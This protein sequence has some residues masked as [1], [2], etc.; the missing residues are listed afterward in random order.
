[1]LIHQTSHRRSPVL[2]TFPM[3]NAHLWVKGAK[4]ML[5][6]F[7]FVFDLGVSAGCEEDLLGNV[8]P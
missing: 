1:M 3:S 6:A 8:R 5:W 4:Q 7:T 2:K